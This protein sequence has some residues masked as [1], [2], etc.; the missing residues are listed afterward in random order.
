MNSPMNPDVEAHA[1]VEAAL[2]TY[3]ATNAPARFAAGVMARVQALPRRAVV[4]PKF[5]LP[6]LELLVSFIVPVMLAVAW[7]VWRVLPPVFLARL[8]VQGLILWQQVGQQSPGEMLT[9]LLPLG[10]LLA[11]VCFGLAATLFTFQRGQN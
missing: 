8:R 4:R 11:V 1:V 6:W 10:M 7:L 2:Q 3:P 9:W 5:Q